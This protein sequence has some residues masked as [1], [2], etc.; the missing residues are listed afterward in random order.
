[1]LRMEIALF[2]VTGFIAYMY[3]TAEKEPSP[4]HRTFSVL[5]VAVLA[6]LA[7]DGGTIYTVN[8]LETV[9]PLFNSILHRLFLGSMVLVLY[10]FYQYIA[11]SVREETARSRGLDTAAKIFLLL[12]ELGNFLLPIDYTVTPEGNYSSGPYMLVPYAAVAF[13]LLLCAGLL[14]VRWKYVERKSAP[15]SARRSE[16]SCSAALCRACTTAG[17]SAA[18]ASR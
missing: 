8:H 6:H 3:F 18:W 12:A 15:P 5:L 7:L 1:M 2:L 10:L 17:L 14:A 16:L 9:P 11:L 4:L 13:Y